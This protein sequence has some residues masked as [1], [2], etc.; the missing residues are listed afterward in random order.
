MTRCLYTLFRC[1]SFSLDER[2][3]SCFASSSDLSFE[4]SELIVFRYAWFRR[5]S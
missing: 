1:S 3:T 2:L 5:E 4:T